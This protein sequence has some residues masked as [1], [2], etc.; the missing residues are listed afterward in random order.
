MREFILLVVTRSLM[1][2][3]MGVSSPSPQSVQ[4]TG[5]PETIEQIARQFS[6]RMGLAATCLESGRSI[7]LNAD[8]KFQTA[9]VIDWAIVLVEPG[10]CWQ[11][12]GRGLATRGPEFDRLRRIARYGF[13]KRVGDQAMPAAALSPSQPAGDRCDI[14]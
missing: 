8:E 7:F 10:T 9:S 11:L 5:V 12:G 3:A 6:G 13:S 14:Q 2:G 4:T 1:A